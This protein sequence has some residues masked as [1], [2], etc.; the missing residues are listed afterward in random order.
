MSIFQDQKAFMD[1]AGQEGDK[2]LYA[3]LIGEESQEFFDEWNDCW[4]DF[5]LAK[6]KTLINAIKEAID[7]IYVATGF[8]NSCNIDVE[9]AWSAVHDSNMAKVS[10][11]VV[12]REDG[13]VLKPDE[14]KQEAKAKLYARL[15]E[16]LVAGA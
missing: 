11:T 5:S 12:V 9:A 16:L 6:D 2:N 4:F 15:S 13:K 7:V 14:W 8:L 3:N 10:G 1:A